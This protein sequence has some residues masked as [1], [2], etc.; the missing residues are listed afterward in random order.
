MAHQLP[1][2]IQSA[3]LINGVWEIDFP[4]DN[5][6]RLIKRLVISE[7]PRPSTLYVFVDNTKYDTTTRGDENSAEYFV[8]LYVPAGSTISLI[9][10]TGQTSPAGTSP[11]AILFCEGE[12][13]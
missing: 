3:I 7:G 1:P 11:Q 13:I 4:S 5:Q 12:L 9:W 10:D 6:V 8:G 2:V